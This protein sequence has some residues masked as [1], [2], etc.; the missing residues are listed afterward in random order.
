MMKKIVSLA[1][2]AAAVLSLTAC[3]ADKTAIIGMTTK[4]CIRDRVSGA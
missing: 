3:G 4:M 2:A 1:L